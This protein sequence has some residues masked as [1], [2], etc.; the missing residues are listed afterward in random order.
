ALERILAQVDQ[1]RHVRRHLGAGPPGRLHDELELHVIDAD[2]GQFGARKI[3][4]LV[5]FRWPLAQYQF[6]LVVA[7]EVVLVGP[8]TELDALEQLR[9]DVRVA[10]GG[11]ERR[12]PVQAGED[13]VFD[14]ARLDL[15]RP[16]GDARHP[17]AAFV[18]RSLLPLERRVA[19]VRPGERL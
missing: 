2:G 16:A 6:R 1:A 17:E 10:R 14:R 15:A 19:A 13:T 18:T 12:E 3:E 9:G 5:A 11:T 7:V 4:E 8:V